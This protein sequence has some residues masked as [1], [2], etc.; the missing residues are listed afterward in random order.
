MSTLIIYDSF[1]GN[2]Q[3]L[4]QA[5]AKALNAPAVKV[6]EVKPELLHG[7]TLLIVGSPTRAFRPTPAISAFIRTLP[8][9]KLQG[10]KIATFDTRIP[11]TDKVPR[12][13]RLMSSLLG[14]AAQPMAKALVKKGST[15]AVPAEGFLVTDSKGPLAEGELDRAIAWA[16]GLKQ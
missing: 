15:L 7:L 8:A 12:F 6:S 16:T 2:T 3:Q 14:Y 4:A 1:F 5:M 11:M 9:N 10:V 13:L